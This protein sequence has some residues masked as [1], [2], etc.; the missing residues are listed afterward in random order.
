[1][2]LV[3]GKARGTSLTG[4]VYEPDDE[5]PTYAG[6][7]DIGAPYV[8]VCDSFYEVES[9]G[10]ALHLDGRTVRVAFESPSP[11]GYRSVEEALDAAGEHIRTQF[12]RIGV[13][14]DAVDIEVVRSP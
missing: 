1:M 8:W 14:K 12:A 4:T 2:I 10:T 5:P 9:G 11:R 7:P 3:R 13:E 6:A